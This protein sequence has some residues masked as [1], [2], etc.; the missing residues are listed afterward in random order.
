[1]NCY[2]KIILSDKLASSRHKGR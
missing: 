1:M 2:K